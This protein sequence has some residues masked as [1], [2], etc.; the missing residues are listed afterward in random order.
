MSDITTARIRTDDGTP[1]LVSVGCR[2]A[3]VPHLADREV[4][5]CAALRRIGCEPAGAYHRV[6]PIEVVV[7]VR[8]APA[9]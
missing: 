7:P 3:I 5:I 9:P 2:H 6:N 1:V 4:A 8:C